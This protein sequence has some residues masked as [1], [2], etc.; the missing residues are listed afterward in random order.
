MHF[1]GPQPEVVIN[2]VKEFYANYDNNTPETVFVRG[3]Q[4]ELTSAAINQ[5]Y[6]LGD[7]DD[8]YTEFREGLDEDKLDELLCSVYGP[9]AEW[10]KASRRSMT[11][12]RRYL[13]LEAKL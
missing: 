9:D 7:D 11:V 4:I 10:Q 12:L 3:R 13:K 8:D 1:C 6:Q 5:I 2:L